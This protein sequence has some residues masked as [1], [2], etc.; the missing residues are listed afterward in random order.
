MQAKLSVLIPCKNEVENLPACIGPICPAQW[1]GLNQCLTGCSDS[2]ISCL[3]TTCAPQLDAMWSCLRE[4]LLA[5]Q[6]NTAFE[7]CGVGF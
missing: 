7:S 3:T 5:G 1:L 2:E 4:P 6:C